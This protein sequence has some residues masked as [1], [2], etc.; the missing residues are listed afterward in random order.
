MAEQNHRAKRKGNTEWIIQ[1]HNQ[2]FGQ[3]RIKSKKKR[4]VIPDARVG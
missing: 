2:Q 3:H 4:R 1:G